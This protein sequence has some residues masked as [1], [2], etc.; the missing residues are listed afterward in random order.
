MV[1]ADISIL[2]GVDS[3]GICKKGSTSKGGGH[4]LILAVRPVLH[5]ANYAAASFLEKI[6][7][8]RSADSTICDIGVAEYDSRTLSTKWCPKHDP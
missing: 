2:L 8:K 4:K 7:A 3:G 1:D 5:R 6:R